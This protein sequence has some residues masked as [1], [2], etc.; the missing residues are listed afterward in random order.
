MPNFLPRLVEDVLNDSKTEP[1]YSAVYTSNMIKCYIYVM[2]EL[3]KVLP[4]S[5][6]RA[7]FEFHSFTAEEYRI[8]EALREKEAKYYR[9]VQY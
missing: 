1:R 4:Y 8:F 3:G 2:Q 7:F 5:T 6:V 9:G